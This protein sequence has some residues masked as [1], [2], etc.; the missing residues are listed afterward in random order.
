MQA[1][2]EASGFATLNVGY[3]S[4]RKTL[5]RLADDIHP[6]IQCFADGTEGSVHFVGHSMGGLLAR[7]YL[8]RYRPKRL[9]RV[10]M[11]GTPNGGSEIADRLKDF[12]PYR[13]WFGPAGQQLGTIRD[14]ALSLMLPPVDYPVGI[15]AGNRSVYPLA[16][17][18][19]P[20]PNDGRVSVEN[21]KL[22][23]M[24]DHIV[25]GA[26]HPWLPRNALAIGQTM[27]FLRDGRFEQG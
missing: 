23:G 17:A 16:S 8:G 20:R 2:I 24:A 25:I 21:T 12:L 3:A 10:V 6:A 22:D 19:L 18:L 26:S 1:A 9:G 11:L 14:A 15:I 4:R 13:A 7:V 5:E 27:A